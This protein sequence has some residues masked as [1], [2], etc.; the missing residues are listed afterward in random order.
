MNVEILQTMSESSRPALGD[1]LSST[2]VPT[3][4]R[5]HE[6]DLMVAHKETVAEGVVALT[7]ADAN[8]RE[9]PAWTP[10]AHIDLVVP[11]PSPSRQYS[12][13]GHPADRHAWR[14]GVLRE[15]KSRGGSQF[16]HDVL[17]AGDTVRVRGPRNHFALV[18]APRYL[19]IAGGIG[20][21]PLLPMVASVDAVGADWQLWYGGHSRAS[22]AFLDELAGYGDRIRIYAGD[23]KGRIPLGSVLAPPR[24]DTLVYCCGP[25]DLLVAVEGWCTSWPVGSLHFERFKAKPSEA[26]PPVVATFEVILQR[27]G[28][29]VTVPPDKSIIEVVEAAGL[30]VLSAC[31]QGICGTCEQAVLEGVPDHRDSVLTPVEREAGE[32]M[33][34][35][36][37]RSCTPRLVLDL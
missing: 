14:I 12:L 27:S 18:D 31:R 37:S 23:E 32:V 8:G 1:A 7:L 34:I 2:A 30:Y 15:A 4:Y 11:D 21:T 3:L 16:I 36:V 26:A 9:L 25:E 28:I 22:M 10:G 35:C 6:A 17:Q 29:T 19:F 20:I 33:M 13:C 5:E 24:Q